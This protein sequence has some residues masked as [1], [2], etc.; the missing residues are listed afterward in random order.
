MEPKRNGSSMEAAALL[1]TQTLRMHFKV[2]VPVR[3]VD[4]IRS[5]HVYQPRNGHSF[6][7]RVSR[8]VLAGS[9]IELTRWLDEIV[10]HVRQTPPE[11]R[12]YEIVKEGLRITRAACCP[13]CA[14]NWSRSSTESRR[15]PDPVDEAVRGCSPRA[16][17]QAQGP[18][19]IRSTQSVHSL[20]NLSVPPRPQRLSLSGLEKRRS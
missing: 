8:E 15:S 9:E 7:V 19:R 13:I 11:P 1:V 16:P 5:W 6:G 4:S 3:V 2:A 18:D 17:H 14:S 10:D 20:R 12:L